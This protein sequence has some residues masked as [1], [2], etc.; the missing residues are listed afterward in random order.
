MTTKHE[1]T[2]HGDEL[3]PGMDV[4][5]YIVHSKVGEGGMGIVYRAQHPNIG[6]RVAIK[7]LGPVFCRDPEVVARFEQEARLVNEIHHSN[8]VDIFQLGVLQDGRK[9]LVMELLEG[10]SLSARI[11]RG[12]I[13]APEAVG[14]LDEIADALIATHEKGIVH[15]DMKSDNVFLANLR[16]RITVK[17][18]DFG[19][20]KLS[21]NDPRAVTK[22]KTG[23]VVGTPHY[24]SPEQIRGKPADHRTDVYSLG[25]LAYKMLVGDLP[26]EGLPTDLLIH[27]LKTP[28]PPVTDRAPDV[29]V[30]LSQMVQ[31][32][33]GKEPE[34]RP[35]LP[36]LRAFLADLRAGRH[37]GSMA[38][39]A[40]SSSPGMQMGTGGM[41]AMQSTP[42]MQGMQS[43]PGMQAQGGAPGKRPAWVYAVIALAV[44]AS[45]G[46]AF[47]IV[48]ALKGGG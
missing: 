29:P 26:W 4:G 34:Q 13:P 25:I 3:L 16:G 37:T 38:P 43:T 40:A 23:I 15:R 22:T 31:R 46:A 35:T 21:G 8:I 20:A 17:L 47:G 42:A 28:P 36:E 6:K 9:Y 10:E 7:V 2:A 44:F 30:P 14:I 39:L 12:R 18:L 11:E 48:Y 5:G 32:M 24:M 41:Q 33:M 27:H 1:S 19:L 45:A